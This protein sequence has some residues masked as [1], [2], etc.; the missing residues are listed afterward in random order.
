MGFVMQR[1]ITNY[2]VITSK[3]KNTGQVSYV[4]VVEIFKYITLDELEIWVWMCKI[5]ESKIEVS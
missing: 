1:S 2:V 4:V 3:T 5:L